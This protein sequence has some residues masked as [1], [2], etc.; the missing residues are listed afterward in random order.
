MMIKPFALMDIPRLR[1]LDALRVLTVTC[2]ESAKVPGKLV[3]YDE[4]A[5]KFVLIAD[6]TL[7]VGPVSDH[8]LLLGAYHLRALPIEDCAAKLAQL[9]K[10]EAHST[11]IFRTLK[12]SLRPIAAGNIDTRGNIETWRSEGFEVS[13]REKLKPDI[14]RAIHKMF[15]DG[16][17]VV[18]KS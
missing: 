11:D 6:D 14:K 5:Y 7:V 8:V 13:T 18:D 2:D 4:L 16:L 12:Y 1:K 3:F 10:I 17:I 9:S 15:D